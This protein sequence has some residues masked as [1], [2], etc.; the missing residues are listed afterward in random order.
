M[1]EDLCRG[2]SQPLRLRA[3]QAQDA[4]RPA[5]TAARNVRE[6]GQGDRGLLRGALHG[7]GIAPAL[8]VV[9][10]QDGAADDRQVGVGADEVVREARDEVQQADEALLSDAHGAVGHAEHDAVLVI[11][12][13][14][15]ILQRPG[16]AAQGQRD[17]AVVGAGRVADASGVALVLRAERAERITRRLRLAR[18]GDVPRVLLRLGLVDRDI[19]R[20]EGALEDPALVPREAV[21]ADVV[22]VE[23]ELVI[24]VR[25]R[26]GAL[27]VLLPKDAAHL[28]RA[29]RD[30]VHELRVEDVPALAGVRRDAARDGLVRE[31][32][33][34]V[35][36]RPG[37]RPGRAGDVVGLVHHVQQQIAGVDLLVGGDEPRADGVARQGVDGI[38][39]HRSASF[40]ISCAPSQAETA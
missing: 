4:Q 17:D 7:E 5:H 10:A 2:G 34:H 30:A 18:G 27:G 40:V 16:L 33:E 28:G 19:Q 21:A 32:G 1:G 8:E 22:A 11:V 24:E 37:A 31:L 36:Q 12:D 20:A 26:L 3:P 39:Q 13:V 35:S 6:A 14:G 29:R 9:V 25:R 23:R 38:V 15:G